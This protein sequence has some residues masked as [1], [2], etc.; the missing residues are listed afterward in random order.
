MD[1]APA[2]I[3]FVG[4]S[5]IDYETA[6]AA[7]MPPALVTW[8]YHPREVLASTPAPLLDDPPALLR[9]LEALRREA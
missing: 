4:D 6:C 2:R 8:G 9:H 7:G 5:T 1:L 3:A